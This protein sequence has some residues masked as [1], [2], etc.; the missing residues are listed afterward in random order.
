MARM[1]LS[2]TSSIANEKTRMPPAMRLA[3]IRGSVMRRSARRGGEPRFTA[4]SSSETLTCW[5]PAYAARTIYGSRRIAYAITSSGM[6]FSLGSRNVPA[7]QATY[8]NASTT[9]GMASGSITTASNRSAPLNRFLT[10]TYAMV[11]PSTTSTTVLR[12]L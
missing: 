7:K 2:L 9:P 10:S 1:R 11:T 3:L 12:E 4:A 6:G 8:P 5:N